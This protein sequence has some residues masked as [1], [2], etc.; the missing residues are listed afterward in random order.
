ML[1]S[2]GNQEIIALV[3]ENRFYYNLIPVIIYLFVN[4]AIGLLFAEI[5]RNE[6]TMER[7]KEDLIQ[8]EK[9]ASLGTLTAG[10]AHEINN[11]L[12]FISGSLHALY[13]LKDEYLKLESGEVPVREKIL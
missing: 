1:V 12:N 11:P 10:I 13:T 3:V 7:Q 9:M 8:A 2:D 6:M 4:L 5:Y